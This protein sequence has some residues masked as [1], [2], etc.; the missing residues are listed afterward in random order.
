MSTSLEARYRARSLWLDLLPG[1]L[2][3]RPAL[4]GD[5]ELDVAVVGAGFTGLWTAYAL[6]LGDPA[7]R[8]AVLEAEI[9]GYGASGRNA[10]FVSAGIAG[11]PRVYARTHGEEA[12]LRAERAVVDAID[13]IGAV[14]ERERIDCGYVKGGSLRIATSGPQLERVRRSFES[15]RPVVPGDDGLRLLDAEGIRER[16]RMEG[17]RGGVFTPHCARVNP[18]A[19]ARGLAEACERRGVTIFEQTRVRR[20]EPGRAVCETGTVRAPVVLRATESYTTGLPG[21]R[22]RLLPVFSHMIATEPLPDEVWERIGW[23]GSETIADQHYHFFYAQRTPDG[24]I[25]VGG[26]GTPYRFGNRIREE[27]ES[28]PRVH[29]GLEAALRRHFPQLAE[30]GITHRWGG[31]FAAPRDWSMGVAFDPR[32]GLGWSGGYTGHGVVGSNVGARTLA[33]LV[34]GVDSELTGLPWVGHAARRWEPEPL[35]WLATRV[36]PG[37]LATADRREDRSDR[38]ARRVRLVRRWLPAR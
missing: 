4:P 37:V 11:Q 34:R 27:D 7:L 25:A 35:R 19:L 36:I 10:G 26:R 13:W 3:A 17:V 33:D 6:A 2:G 31:P 12:V 32:T 29:A 38:A 16:V 15:R 23:Q 28:R 14:V 9:A 24:R 21:E 8:I 22:R 5:R 18:A 20:I 30:A 1:P